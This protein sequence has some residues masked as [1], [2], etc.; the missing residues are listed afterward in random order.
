MRW[1]ISS[2]SFFFSFFFFSDGCGPFFLAA[3]QPF[4]P[5]IYR[6]KWEASTVSSFLHQTG[7]LT[8][9]ARSHSSG[10][11]LL[12]PTP[13]SSSR[14][15]IVQSHFRH[16]LPTYPLLHIDH[17][18]NVL[19]ST[20]YSGF[21]LAGPSSLAAGASS[22]SASG[23][24]SI[25]RRA[26]DI[27]PVL[28][29]PG[30]PYVPRSAA[31]EDEQEDDDD[32]ETDESNVWSKE[33]GATWVDD[34]NAMAEQGAALCHIEQGGLKFLAPISAEGKSGARSGLQSR[35]SDANGYILVLPRRL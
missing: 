2:S 10:S 13:A 3:I 23:L 35:K 1:T 8:S 14:R 29:V 31:D 21:S 15:P 33:H 16:P 19:S 27:R 11:R 25:P 30:I 18:N 5:H 34:S 24:K 17:F 4:A 26:Q 9:C 12:T 6:S 7:E 28:W 32:E 22:S 20:A